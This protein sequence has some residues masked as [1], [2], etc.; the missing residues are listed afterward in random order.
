MLAAVNAAPGPD[1]SVCAAPGPVA[2]VRIAPGPT[3]R[4]APLDI[5]TVDP[6]ARAD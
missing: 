1:A 5:T 3:D 6:S 4:G 2:S